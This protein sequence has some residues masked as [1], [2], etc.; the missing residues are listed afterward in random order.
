MQVWFRSSHLLQGAHAC[1]MELVNAT[2]AAATGKWLLPNLEGEL[3]ADNPRAANLS[4]VQAQ[5][6]LRRTVNERRQRRNLGAT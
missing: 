4:R 2:A 3:L 5:L 6:P 1:L